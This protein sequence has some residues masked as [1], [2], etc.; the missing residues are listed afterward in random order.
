MDF[1]EEAMA[2]KEMMDKSPLYRVA[3]YLLLLAGGGLVIIVGISM[4]V[5]PLTIF[6]VI[7]IAIIPLDIFVRIRKDRFRW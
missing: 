3:M 7:C 4:S 1:W 2:R 5:L 6:G